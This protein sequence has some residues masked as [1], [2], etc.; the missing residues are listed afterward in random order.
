MIEF[1]IEVYR[2]FM[3]AVI[4]DIMFL[5]TECQRASHGHAVDPRVK[6]IHKLYVESLQNFEASIASLEPGHILEFNAPAAQTEAEAASLAPVSS[7]PEPSASADESQTT[8]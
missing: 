5:Q 1:P 2:S 6:T 7:Q 8:A 4:V 3:A